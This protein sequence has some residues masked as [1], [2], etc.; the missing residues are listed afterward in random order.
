MSGGTDSGTENLLTKEQRAIVSGL[1]GIIGQQL[2]IDV[3]GTTGKGGGSFLEKLMGGKPGAKIGSPIGIG[4]PDFDAA[5]GASSLQKKFF[6]ILGG[7]IAGL[8]SGN[9]ESIRGML[10]P[11]AASARR[12]FYGPRG[13]LDQIMHKYGSEGGL[14]GPL[15]QMMLDA[16]VDFET[17]LAGGQFDTLRSLMPMATQALQTGGDTQRQVSTQQ[18]MMQQPWANP[19]LQY[20]P[21]ALSPTKVAT[22][23][24]GGFL[25]I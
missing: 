15:A 6:D 20:L 25:G 17:K 7:P 3:G 24:G 5:V 23:S 1:A 2:G 4:G 14:S 18:W 10:E 8:A 11:S 19:W 21:T 9:I 22:T 12:D 13:A 16:G